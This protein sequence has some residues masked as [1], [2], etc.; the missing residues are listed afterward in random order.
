MEEPNE[1]PVPYPSFS[2]S[3]QEESPLSHTMTPQGEGHVFDYDFG[4]G[5]A[6]QQNG[7]G[8][9]MEG[10]SPTEELF[11]DPSED[12]YSFDRSEGGSSDPGT[13]Q[14]SINGDIYDD[15]QSYEEMSGAPDDLEEE[16]L[17][18]QLLDQSSQGSNDLLSL[19]QD[20]YGQ[21]ENDAQSDASGDLGPGN[22]ISHEIVFGNEDED[23]NDSLPEKYE[24]PKMWSETEDIEDEQDDLPEDSL[25]HDQSI[26]E[27]LIS[28]ESRS[29]FPLAAGRNTSEHSK[30]HENMHDP[31]KVYGV[32]QDG[33][34]RKR[35]AFEA[36]SPLRPD[37]SSLRVSERSS[38]N[39]AVHDPAENSNSGDIQVLEGAVGQIKNMQSALWRSR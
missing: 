4:D 1:V 3:S 13:A 6:D 14:T 28:R 35:S 9:S 15:E 31:T 10:L 38:R 7:D 34:S 26:D 30:E 17:S 32:R 27:S 8:F 33:Q 22:D 25:V 23:D 21:Q 36:V 20:E 24:Q 11:P 29:T 2:E 18:M 12:H 37:Q 5:V 39:N 19:V 16:E